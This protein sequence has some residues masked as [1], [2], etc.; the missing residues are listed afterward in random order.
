MVL[1]Q[2]LLHHHI[3]N[4]DLDD[5]C[6][7][8]VSQLGVWPCNHTE[9][10]L[11]AKICR[12]SCGLCSDSNTTLVTT[13]ATIST[14]K[15]T[16]TASTVSFKQSRLTSTTTTTT[17]TTA[18]PTTYPTTTTATATTTITTTTTTTTMTTTPVTTTIRPLPVLSADVLFVIDDSP[19]VYSTQGCT[20]NRRKDA[21]L[22]TVGF[23]L[24]CFD[25]PEFFSRSVC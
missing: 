8:F 22:D 7:P 16:K 11:M 13:T 20:T 1:T 10:P 4:R 14:A 2:L 15:F 25:F 24:S 19:G 17:T 5:N 9:L 6:A 3:A 21:V 18:A 12:K 23:A